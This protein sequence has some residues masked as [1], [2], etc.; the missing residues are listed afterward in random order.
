M[1]G[2][3]RV[4]GGAG[5]RFGQRQQPVGLFPGKI[6]RVDEV[7]QSGAL[8]VEGAKLV[9]SDGRPVQLRGISTHGIAWFPDYINEAAFRQFRT[10]WGANVVRLAM[11][12]AE[13][14]GYCSGGDLSASGKWLRNMLMS[15][16][17]AEIADGT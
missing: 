12:A 13:Y 4:R 5:D 16:V 11:Y 6:Q 10:E 2:D 14:G 7:S 1:C 3:F 8:H 17:G 9:G 15:G